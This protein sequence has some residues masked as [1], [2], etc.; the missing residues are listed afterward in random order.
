MKR[1]D[2]ITIVGGAAVAW[3][4]AARAQQGEQRRHIGVLTALAEDDPE[5]Q[6]RLAGLRYGLER[7]GWSEGRNL[8]IDYRF[9]PGWLR[10]V[11][12]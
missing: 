5:N 7:R 12:G 10:P 2:F 4:L 9:A 1:R 11:T 8:R 3:P 6:P